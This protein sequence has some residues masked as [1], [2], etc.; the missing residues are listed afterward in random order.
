MI[1]I[2]IEVNVTARVYRF[3][4]NELERMPEQ[5]VV[6]KELFQVRKNNF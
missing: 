3:V 5:D 4:G 1:L 2:V 6:R